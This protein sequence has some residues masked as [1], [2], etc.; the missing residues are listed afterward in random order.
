MQHRDAYIN[1]QCGVDK[2]EEE[3]NEAR[4]QKKRLS[5]ALLANEDVVVGH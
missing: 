4:K 3:A 5:S 1:Y 2:E